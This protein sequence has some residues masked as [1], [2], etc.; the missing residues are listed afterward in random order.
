MDAAEASH[1]HTPTHHI[2]ATKQACAKIE[3]EH[4]E[5]TAQ[6]DDWGRF[7]NFSVLVGLRGWDKTKPLPAGTTKRLRAIVL[8]AFGQA[9]AHIRTVFPPEMRRTRGVFAGYDRA[10]WGFDIDYQ[11]FDPQMNSFHG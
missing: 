3:A 6:V 10:F 2:E 1:H 5:I 8:E 9:G 11:R 7:S 4:P